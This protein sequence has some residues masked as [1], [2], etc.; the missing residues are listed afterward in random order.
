MK[1]LNNKCFKVTY[2]KRIGGEG[3]ILVKCHNINDAITLASRMCFTGSYFRN[4]IEVP[5]ENYSKTT[6]Q[7]FSG[8]NRAN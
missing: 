3:T 1:N 5:L 7:G 2:T 6:N 8:S 4:P